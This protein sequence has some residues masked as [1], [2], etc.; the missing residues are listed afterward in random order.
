MYNGKVTQELKILCTKYEDV[1]GYNPNGDMEIEFG[2][3]EYDEYIVALKKA[4]DTK[5][6]IFTVLNI[7]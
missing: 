5:K 1:F 7:V 6:D 3:S 2:E 4:I